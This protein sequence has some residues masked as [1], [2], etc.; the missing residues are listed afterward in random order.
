MAPKLLH[1]VL[2]LLPLIV[3]ASASAQVPA[4]IG[5]NL[6]GIGP[7]DFLFDAGAFAEFGPVLSQTPV[8][9]SVL[10]DAHGAVADCQVAPDVG[11]SAAAAGLRLC[12]AIRHGSLRVPNWYAPYMRGGHIT[13]ELHADRG[14]VP[15]RPVQIVSL[16]QGDA[17]TIMVLFGNC[18]V[19]SPAMTKA[20]S[21]VVCAA[22]D[23]AGR[24]GLTGAPPTQMATCQARS[25][26]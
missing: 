11:K 22:F 2:A 14:V 12:G 6:D 8:G 3:A 4:S 16:P 20:D 9:I 25:R 18:L 26:T 24:P 19:G 7:F 15:S 21:G 17:A 1:S 5:P 13:M 23:K 10:I